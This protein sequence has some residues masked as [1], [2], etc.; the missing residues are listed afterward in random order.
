MGISVSA[1]LKPA[2]YFQ[3]YDLAIVTEPV[4]DKAH[5]FTKIYVI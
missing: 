1:F 2:G 5:K 3:L 4:F